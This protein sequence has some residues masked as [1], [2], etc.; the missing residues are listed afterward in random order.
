MSYDELLEAHP[1]DVTSVLDLLVRHKL[2]GSSD[3]SAIA[4]GRVVFACHVAGNG[5]RKPIPGQIAEIEQWERPETVSKLQAYL[6]FCNYYSGYIKMYAEYAAPMTTMLKG[7]WEVTK[8][9][10]K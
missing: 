1:R 10:S 6:G 8:K 9:G 2:M 3:N 5:Q 4:V 7:N